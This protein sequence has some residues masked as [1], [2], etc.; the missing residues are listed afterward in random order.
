MAPSA[1]GLTWMPVR[2]RVLLDAAV[3][4]GTIRAGVDPLD[5]LGG[6]AKL[7]I[8][9]VG[10]DDTSRASR[11]IALLMDGLRYRAGR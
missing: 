3:A 2:P 8:P 5:L 11:M 4:A 7:R 6:V 10:T 1:Y 9:P